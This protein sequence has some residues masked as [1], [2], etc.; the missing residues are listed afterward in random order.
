MTLDAIKVK[1]ESTMF[2]LKSNIYSLE[3]L[4]PQEANNNL[5]EEK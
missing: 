5:P 2:Y 3:G 4:S 1:N